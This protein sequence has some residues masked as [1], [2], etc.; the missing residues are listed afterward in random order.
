MKINFK[1]D[2]ERY[3]ELLKHIN[4]QI[5]CI[6]LKSFKHLN[7]LY[8]CL[9]CETCGVVLMDAQP[10]ESPEI[11]PEEKGEREVFVEKSS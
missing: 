9:F 6:D 4:H 2:I 8:V 5:V 1:D 10:P 7:P 11:E 3:Q